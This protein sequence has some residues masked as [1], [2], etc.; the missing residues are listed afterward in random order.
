MLPH[1]KEDPEP[2]IQKSDCLDQDLL[3]RLVLEIVQVVICYDIYPVMPQV[4]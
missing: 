1:S 3:F 2:G 4:L